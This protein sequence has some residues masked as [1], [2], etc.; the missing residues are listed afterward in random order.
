MLMG[1]VPL[2]RQRKAASIIPLLEAALGT[3]AKA[4]ATAQRR[5]QRA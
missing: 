3:T 1:S 4:A 5:W 2:K